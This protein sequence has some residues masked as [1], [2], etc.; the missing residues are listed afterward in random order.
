MKWKLENKDK[1]HAMLTLATN[2][3]KVIYFVLYIYI[4]FFPSLNLCIPD[5]QDFLQF[6]RHVKC[7]LSFSPSNR[8]GVETDTPSSISTT[9]S[10]KKLTLLKPFLRLYL[11]KPDLF[12]A[13]FIF[14]LVKKPHPFQLSE[15]K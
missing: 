12:G 5:H 6:L 9:L 10:F 15:R 8:A 4:Y 1:N 2:I 14:P 11:Q 13:Q 7:L 3:L